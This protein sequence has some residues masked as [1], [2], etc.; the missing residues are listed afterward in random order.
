[1]NKT[2]KT[3]VTYCVYCRS[4]DDAS[5]FFEVDSNKLRGYVKNEIAF[6]GDLINTSKAT[7]RKTKLLPF[8][9]PPCRRIAHGVADSGLTAVY[10]IPTAKSVYVHYRPKGRSLTAYA[11]RTWRCYSCLYLPLFVF[12]CQRT[13]A[14]HFR[15]IL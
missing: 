11:D 8:L 2:I 7:S 3:L 14:G 9:G 10:F 1:L 12:I 4:L 15:R 5:L 6:G 13:T